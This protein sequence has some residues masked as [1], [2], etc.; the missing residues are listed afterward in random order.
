[1]IDKFIKGEELVMQYEVTKPA[2][3][4]ELLEMT[5]EEIENLQR[6]KMPMLEVKD[7]INNFKETELGFSR[8]QAVCEAKHCLRCDKEEKE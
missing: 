2:A 4:V 3:D 6:F 7:R 5:E 8:N 1:M